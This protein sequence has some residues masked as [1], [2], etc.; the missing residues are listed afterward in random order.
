MSRHGAP[1]RS[2]QKMPLTTPLRRQQWL[3]HAPLEVREIVAYDPA[4]E[5]E[6]LTHPTL[7]QLGALKLDGMADAPTV[8]LQSLVASQAL[9]I[10]ASERQPQRCLRS[11]SAPMH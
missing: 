11:C 2:T 1:V 4:P 9:P 3:D 6:M 5:A 10:A 7:D 8:K